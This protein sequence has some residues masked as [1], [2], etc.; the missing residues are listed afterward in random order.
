[1]SKFDS[2]P[3][4]RKA[5]TIE[6]AEQDAQAVIKRAR[7]RGVDYIVIVERQRTY[8]HRYAAAEYPDTPVQLQAHKREPRG[9]RV[10]L[11]LPDDWTV[12]E[13]A[14]ELLY[15]MR[16]VA[17]F[18][19]Q[20]IDIYFGDW[21][22]LCRRYKKRLPEGSW[23]HREGVCAECMEEHLPHE[24]DVITVATEYTGGG[25]KE[26]VRGPF[27]GRYDQGEGYEVVG[28]DGQAVMG[29]WLSGE[30]IERKDTADE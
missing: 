24:G 12:D 10:Y 4:V 20:Q 9:G 18:T 26:T 23:S 14:H 19:E 13:A 2:M 11:Y 27:T 6:Q 22:H 1:M 28:P 30:G 17:G 3:E 15:R 7:K 5:Y 21:C 8:A 29:L 25:N 16:D